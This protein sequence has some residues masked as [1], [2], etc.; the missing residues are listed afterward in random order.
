MQQY[1]PSITNAKGY[2]PNAQA[3]E[4]VLAAALV[5]DWCYALLSQNDKAQLISEMKRV[6]CLAE[7]CIFKNTPKQY[8]SGH[9]G[10]EAP[11]VF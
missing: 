4:A 6:S 7:Y 3:Y 1:L 11:T 2:H 9:Y 8:L 10:E 5:Y